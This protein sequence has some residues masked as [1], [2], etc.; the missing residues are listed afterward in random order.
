MLSV[1]IILVYIF[2]LS[3]NNSIKDR[4]S[5]YLYT[6]I[7]SWHFFIFLLSSFDP[8]GFYPVSLYAYSLSILSI[9]FFL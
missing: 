3:L 8:L 1:L 9:V 2:L 6:F 5:C 4:F 7:V